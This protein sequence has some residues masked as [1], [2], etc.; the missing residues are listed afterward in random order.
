MKELAEIAFCA[1]W[2]HICKAADVKAAFEKWWA[3]YQDA[4]MPAHVC[5]CSQCEHKWTTKKYPSPCP[6]CGYVWH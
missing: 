5:Q 3:D 1:G 6:K 4:R 2:Q